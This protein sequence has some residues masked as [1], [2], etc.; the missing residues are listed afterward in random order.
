MIVIENALRPVIFLLVLGL[1]FLPIQSAHAWS[2]GGHWSPSPANPVIGTHDWIAEKAVELLPVSE[3]AVFKNNINW[4]EY[5]S[6]L[7]DRPKNMSGYDDHFNHHVY[8]NEQRQVTDDADARRANETYHDALALLKKGNFSGGV[9]VAGAMSHYI[10]D[11]AVWGHLMG[12]HTPWGVEKHHEDYENYVNDHQSMFDQSIMVMGPLNRTSAYQETLDLASNIMFVSPNAT[13][14]DTHYNWS[15]PQ[16]KTRVGVSL[17]L[18]AN[19]VANVFNT[20]WLDAGQPLPELSTIYLPVIP[21]VAMIFIISPNRA[22]RT[23]RKP[24]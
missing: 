16:F 4:L 1:L 2:N 8:F 24:E 18:A 9:M 11:I 12:E 3:S 17:N 6:E 10:S 20:L 7:P 15:D 13:W 19:S 21:A 23:S 5:G 22:L 14:M